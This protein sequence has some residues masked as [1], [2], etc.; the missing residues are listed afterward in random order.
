MSSSRSSKQAS[1][2]QAQTLPK[3]PT[4][5]RDLDQILNGGLPRGRTTLIF[6]EPGSGKTVLGLEILYRGAIN[7]QPG[8]FL[9]FEESPQALRQDASTMGFDLPSLEASGRL[10]L[11]KGSTTH[12]VKV[13]G[14][15]HLEPM[16]AIISGKAQ[17]M[18]AKMVMLD[19]LDVLLSLVE[20]PSKVRGELHCLAEWLSR[21]G[22]TSL[23]TLKP[24]EAGWGKEFKDFFYSMSDCVLALDARVV[25]QITTRRLRVVKYRGSDFGRNEYPFA[26]TSSGIRTIPITAFK[27]L[28]KPFGERLP[29]GVERLDWLLGGGYFRGSCV[30]LAGEP[31]TGKTLLA[32][33]FAQEVCKRGE[34]VLYVS[35]EE[36]AEAL[37]SNVS[38]AGIDLASPA[39][40]GLLAFLAA[41]P[42]SKGAEEHLIEVVNMVEELAPRH[43]V[44]DA[45]SAC[46]RMGGQQAAFDFLMRLLNY[47]KEKGITILLVN[48]TSGSKAHLEI[49][50][51][52][53]SSMID[54]VLFFS[55]V[56]EEGETNRAIQVLKSRGSA[57]S[58]QVRECVITSKGIMLLDPYSGPGGVLTG[59]ARKL[60]EARDAQVARRMEA[61]IRLK[62]ME[63]A[64][65]RAAL[66]AKQARL[67]AQIEKARWE[68]DSLKA[69]QEKARKEKAERLSL[70]EQGIRLQGSTEP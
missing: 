56:H 1:K 31:G 2:P 38:S 6:G 52:G 48:Q 29:S 10:L 8:I 54:T 58:N 13:E 36:S 42:E 46:Q 14:E 25:N 64:R 28:H 51:N 34:K 3:L 32:S 55:Y 5:I 50:G 45:I 15:F 19:A 39:K 21:S 68:L 9:G 60:Q 57:H 61:E 18:G 67:K 24:R 66:E 62:E 43:V 7:G 49:S 26:I 37:V 59:T 16:M 4:H 65:L 63:M 17:E 40:E 12:R 33:S 70:R 20:E 22:L 23:M 53:I 44:V 47:L 69:E 30:L 41:M 11:L 35:F 27:L